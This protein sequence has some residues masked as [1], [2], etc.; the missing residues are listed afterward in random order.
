MS[1]QDEGGGITAFLLGGIIGLATG[2]LLAPKAGKETRRRVQKWIDDWEEKGHE[3]LEEGRE[4]IDE[5]KEVLQRKTNRI[6]RV[7]DPTRK[8]GGNGEDDD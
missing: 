1:E 2:L 6:K 4:L 8:S 3:L 5:G 7:I